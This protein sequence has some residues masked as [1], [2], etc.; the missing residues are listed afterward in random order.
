MEPSRS[1]SV[2]TDLGADELGGRRVLLA[3]DEESAR[4]IMASVLGAMGLDVIETGDG[5]RML[6]AIASHYKGGR[7]PEDLDLIVTDIHMP[8]VSGL[9]MLKGLRA[10]GWT[11]PVIIVTGHET[12]EVRE[13]VARLD[14]LLLPKPL[15][16]D[17]FEH[18]VRTILTGPKRA[19]N[20]P[21]SEARQ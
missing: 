16:L 6:V 15:D 5:G 13:A 14:A 10:A 19:R 17:R 18:A 7:S 20:R 8:V 9:D 3:E 1:G 21:Q 11:T 12:R 4:K 2:T